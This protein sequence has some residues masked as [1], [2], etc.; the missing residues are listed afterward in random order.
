MLAF[1]I[2]YSS[3]KHKLLAL[4][5]MENND[6]QYIFSYNFSQ[7]HL[8]SLF[9]SITRK[10]GFKNNPDLRI[11]K[12]ALKLQRTCIIKSKHANCIIFEE[13][14]SNLIFLLK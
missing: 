13:Q 6:F 9:A 5:V 4:E 7:D 10:N 14:A 12:V 11:F 2:H 1:I 3:F 8:L